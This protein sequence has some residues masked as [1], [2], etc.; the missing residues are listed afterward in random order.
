MFASTSID[1]SNHQPNGCFQDLI[2][3]KLMTNP[4]GDSCGFTVVG[5]CMLFGWRWLY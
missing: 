4:R 5:T 1:Q 2:A 3:D